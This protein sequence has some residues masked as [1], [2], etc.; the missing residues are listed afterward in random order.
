MGL[1]A[2]PVLTHWLPT[3]QPVRVSDVQKRK[4]RKSSKMESWK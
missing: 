4:Y 1:A 3:K 2:L